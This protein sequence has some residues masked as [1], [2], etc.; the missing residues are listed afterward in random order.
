MREYSG[1]DK[2]EDVLSSQE[3]PPRQ[4]TVAWLRRLGPTTGKL[5]KATQLNAAH[6]VGA[7]FALNQSEVGSVIAKD[8]LILA[9]SEGYPWQE[10]VYWDAL[11]GEQVVS[12][13]VCF[14]HH[15]VL[16]IFPSP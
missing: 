3:N 6:P 15:S 11:Y 5:L 14:P 1:R 13:W 16:S 12:V 8:E 2:L 4:E 7:Y 9:L 10:R